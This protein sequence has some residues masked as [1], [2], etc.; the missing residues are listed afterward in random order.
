[1]P[2]T[3]TK[4][5]NVSQENAIS[6]A[7]SQV[8]KA[9]DFSITGQAGSGKTFTIRALINSLREAG[10]SSFCLAPTNSAANNIGGM[11][12]VK[13]LGS[14]PYYDK[15]GNLRFSRG[16]P[17]KAELNGDVLIID[18]AYMV[19]RSD[20]AALR[21]EHALSIIYVG[22]SEQL[23]PVN[24]EKSH[25]LSLSL[26]SAS[27]S[28][29]QRFGH[30]PLVMAASKKILESSNLNELFDALSP[31]PR[32]PKGKLLAK[33]YTIGSY[34]NAACSSLNMA[35]CNRLG[36]D[37]LYIGQR[38]LSDRTDRELGI[39]ASE[40][41]VVTNLEDE[42]V[43]VGYRWFKRLTPDIR[44]EFK[45]WREEL[46]NTGGSW[47]QFYAN[48]SEYWQPYYSLYPTIHKMQGKTIPLV[49]I[50]V[51]DILRSRCSFEM[52]KR[53]LYTGITRAS[54]DL[55]LLC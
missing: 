46:L 22:D 19:P 14:T 31:L 6:S 4:T 52:K 25:L 18:E 3:L 53:L 37:E 16:E 54:E 48:L 35:H 23:A 36:E 41:V 33:G 47:G 42:R 29:S 55:Q 40:E 21:D 11:T 15:R 27:L 2:S 44:N 12:T 26:S 43:E 24:E 9:Q 7:L 50:N 38:L 32:S 13:W 45:A 39:Y 17:L 49:A 28:G 10:Y 51:E 34:T 20:L 8:K 1:M 5:L 30:L